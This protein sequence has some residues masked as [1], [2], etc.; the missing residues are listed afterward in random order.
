[1]AANYLEQLLAEWYE[2]QGYFLRRNVLVGKRAKGGYEGEL[3]IVAFHP[4]KHHLV[5]VEASTDTDAWAKRES[6]YRRKFELGKRHIP[7]LFRGF[8]LPDHIEQLA[9]LVYGSKVSRTTLGGGKIMLVGELLEDIFRALAGSRLA[10]AAIPEHLPIL[11]S[12][13]FVAEYRDL[14][15]RV[16][17]RP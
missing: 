10:S 6:R 1:M 11:R 4:H 5:Q 13:Q 16:L 3:D 12:F 15:T 14:V 9:V 17:G 7:R 2:Y 8:K